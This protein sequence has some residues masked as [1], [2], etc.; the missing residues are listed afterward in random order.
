MSRAI[1]RDTALSGLEEA[2][3]GDNNY[4]R[5][6]TEPQDLKELDYPA[7][8]TLW[9]PDLEPAYCLHAQD[10]GE[11]QAGEPD[12]VVTSLTGGE[13][14]DEF[15][16]ERLRAG[17]EFVLDH[18]EYDETVQQPPCYFQRQDHDSIALQ[19]ANAAPAPSS[20]ESD[21][22][23]SNQTSAPPH[24]SPNELL[25]KARSTCPRFSETYMV[26]VIVVAAAW[27]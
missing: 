24:R 1:K 9:K 22:T 5:A 8:E 16:G 10:K 20:Q 15:T 27:D 12:K 23:L 11:Q 13:G 4:Y 17:M 6:A 18:D 2:V 21:L 7:A 26:G 19:P 25:Q 14:D 3:E